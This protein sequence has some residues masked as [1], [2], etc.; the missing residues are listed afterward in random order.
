MGQ[1]AGYPFLVTQVMHS[2]PN[3]E[4]ESRALVQWTE[5]L[6]AE[7][8]RFLSR[9]TERFFQL[10]SFCSPRGSWPGQSC[11]RV[12]WGEAAGGPWGHWDHGPKSLVQPPLQTSPALLGCDTASSG[13]LWGKVSLVADFS[14]AYIQQLSIGHRCNQLCWHFSVPDSVWGYSSA[15]QDWSAQLCSELGCAGWGCEMEA[16]SFPSKRDL[17]FINV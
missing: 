1:P 8:W 9:T 17:A 6:P 10:N 7:V 5:W 12:L 2:H 3:K 13:C 4:G 16:L 14:P 15:V 11:H